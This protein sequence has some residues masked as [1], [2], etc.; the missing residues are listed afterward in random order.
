[1]NRI[2]LGS[3]FIRLFKFLFPIPTTSL[4]TR[5][6]GPVKLQ[7]LCMPLCWE[8]FLLPKC[9]ILSLARYRKVWQKSY[10]HLPGKTG[11]HSI[12][13]NPRFLLDCFPDRIPCFP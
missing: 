1:M 2:V 11:L 12:F 4:V 10:F 13:L 9:N 7:Q 5:F 8:D 3:K 6:F